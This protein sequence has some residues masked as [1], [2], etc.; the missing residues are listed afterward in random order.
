MEGE[1]VSPRREDTAGAEG[2][3]MR[4]LEALLLAKNR[5][6]EHEL[7]MARLQ[8]ADLTGGTTLHLFSCL[9]A[10]STGISPVVQCA[11]QLLSLATL[12][13][14]AASSLVCNTP[15]YPQSPAN[16]HTNLDVCLA[17]GHVFTS[18]VCPGCPCPPFLDHVT[19]LQDGST[20]LS[21]QP[22]SC[23]VSHAHP[24]QCMMRVKQRSNHMPLTHGIFN[25]DP[26]YVK[27]GDSLCL[28]P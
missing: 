6:L 22:Q 9:A 2:A 26:F 4:S 11:L 8:V 14:G 10:P 17:A 7:T 12:A 16:L 23:R 28:L 3:S 27:W 21:A 1:D 20:D 13:H 19:I 18:K 25:T 15:K 24:K 5:H